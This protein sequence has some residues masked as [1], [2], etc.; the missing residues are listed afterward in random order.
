MTLMTLVASFA[1]LV[2]VGVVLAL[3]THA[4]ATR[5]ERAVAAA[6]PPLGRIITVNGHRLH[7]LTKGTGPDLILLHG[8]SGNLRD[9][10]PL[11]DLLAPDYRVTVF[12][13][14]GLGWSDPIPDG[15]SLTAQARHLATAAAELG[16][17]SPILVGLSFGGTVSLAWALY[18]DLK[19]R[20][21]VLVSSPALPWPGK[22]D[23]WYRLTKTALGKHVAIP[24]VA[25]FVPASYVS[26]TVT[27][28]FAP[29]PVPATYRS[30][31]GEGLAIRRQALHANT[32]QVNALRD[33]IV[34]QS[35]DYQSL[36]LPI[37][38]IHGT[39]DTIV[40]LKVHSGPLSALLPHATLTVLDGAG[41]MPHHSQPDVILAAIARA[42]QL[43]R[44]R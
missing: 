33:A 17:T 22:L 40:P 1:V 9:L 5:R 42:D 2:A 3:I 4:A 41:H 12:D 10:T 34:A 11:I 37:E 44:L 21:L 24:L 19:P 23:P 39:A 25:A 31:V 7:V 13:R 6:F 8:A 43:S 14:P 27:G 32:S 18:A 15:T 16:I 26:A 30:Y 29:D 38:L 28:I 20:A 35:A 36:T